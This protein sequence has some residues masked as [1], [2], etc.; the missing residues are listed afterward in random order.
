MSSP[1]NEKVGAWLLVSGNTRADLA[2][3]IGISRPAL[4]NRLDG[5]AKW[6]WDEVITLAGLLGTSL[7]ELAGIREGGQ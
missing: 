5:T 4:A 1:I 6:N 7:N 2:D 3:A